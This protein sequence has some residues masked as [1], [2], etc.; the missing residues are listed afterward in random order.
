MD[1]PQKTPTMD[2]QKFKDLGFL[3]ELNRQFLHPLGLA[4]SFNCDYDEKNHKWM[5]NGTVTIQDYRDN[6]EYIRFSEDEMD[7]EFEKAIDRIRSLFRENAG[8][9]IEKLGYIVQWPKE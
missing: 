7:K 3:Q 5:T 8:Q 9:R 2:L 6:P 1:E 4:L